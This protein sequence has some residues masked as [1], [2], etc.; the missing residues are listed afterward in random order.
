MYSQDLATFGERVVS[1]SREMEESEVYNR[2]CSLAD[3]WVIIDNFVRKLTILE[4]E[5]QDLIELQELLETNVV[6]F[7]ILPS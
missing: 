4:S 6:D 7:D 5:A 1:I 3:A 2:E